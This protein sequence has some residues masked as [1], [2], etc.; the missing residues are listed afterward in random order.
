MKKIF[1][2]YYLGLD[3]GTNSVG[4]AVTDENYNILKFSGKYMWGSRL[5]NEAETAKKRRDNRTMR[6]RLHR[7]RW[8]LNLLNEI[9]A[10][11][12]E[13]TDPYFLKVRINE[14]KLHE[15]D[16]Q[17][18]ELRGLFQAPSFSDVDYYQKYPT[19]Y[20][21]RKDLMRNP[22]KD[23]RLLY[24][25]IHHILKYRGNFLYE[26]EISLDNTYNLAITNWQDE[27]NQLISTSVT[28][29]DDA[30]E[31]PPEHIEFSTAQKE[32]IEQ[33]ITSPAR[34]GDKEKQLKDFFKKQK[35]LQTHQKLIETSFKA[36]CGLSANFKTALSLDTDFK[37]EFS[38]GNFEDKRSEL[39]GTIGEQI[40]Y[41]DALKQ[42][43]DYTI[44]AKILDTKCGSQ[45][46]SISDTYVRKYEK[47]GIDLKNTKYILKKICPC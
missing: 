15:E 14:S 7:R 28:E 37:I 36:I 4:W 41:I 12:L 35:L 20:H 45:E 25:A 16:R 32:T 22:T 47:F 18:K 17:T 27:L 26:R 13:K 40:S 34:R 3:I 2:E 24:L 6:R 42:L 8:R 43:Y 39:E 33:I 46:V 44:I 1:P 9:F 29:N 30:D 11:E 19:I 10:T 5:F 23:I 21:L 31:L 38:K